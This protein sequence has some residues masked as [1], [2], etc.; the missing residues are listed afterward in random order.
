LPLTINL[1]KINGKIYAIDPSIDNLNYIKT[2]C[3]KNNIDNL[4][5]IQ[6]ALCEKS[7][8]KMSII[9]NDDDDMFQIEIVEFKMKSIKYF[10]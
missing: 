1:K 3:L 10:L 6:K 7:N 5:T 2:V 4:F 8:K 9:E